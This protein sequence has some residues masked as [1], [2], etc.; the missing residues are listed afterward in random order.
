MPLFWL[1]VYQR[2]DGH[3]YIPDTNR[4]GQQIAKGFCLKR[5]FNKRVFTVFAVSFG[6]IMRARLQLQL[7]RCVAWTSKWLLAF[8]WALLW[9]I[10]AVSERLRDVAAQAGAET[11]LLAI[12]LSVHRGLH[13]AER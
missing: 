11:S 7:K 6:W 2:F 9:L 4:F 3:C 8:G 1:T 5:I 12:Q 10:R 13:M